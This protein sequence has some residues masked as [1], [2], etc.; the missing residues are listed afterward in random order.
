[1]K[2][3]VLYSIILFTILASCKKNNDR[4]GKEKK[5]SAAVVNNINNVFSYDAQGRLQRIDYG[6]SH[7]LL[8]E[9][10]A[11]GTVLQWYLADGTPIATRRY[12]FNL[13]DGRIVSG[14]ESKANSR[15]VTHSYGYDNEGRLTEHSARDVYEP[16]NEEAHRVIF[17]YSYTGNN[18]GKITYLHFDQGLRR[19]SAVITQTYYTN[20]KLFTWQAV[21][22]G[23][24]G[25]T[26]SGLPHQGL[27]ISSPIT[28]LPFQAYYPSVNALK[29]TTRDQ[30]EWNIAQ[31]KWVYKNTSGYTLPETDY[32]YNGEGYLISFSGA[33]KIEWNQK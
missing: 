18:A 2:Q 32:E 4:N 12:E 13:L 3:I 1:M 20:K 5:I 9:Y 23:F 10:K 21:G 6:V 16:T 17:T 27:G 11:A 33:E 7:Y 25:Q 28:I 14:K 15:I 26:A 29:E 19:D 30:Y 24:F 8:V 22:F 31:N